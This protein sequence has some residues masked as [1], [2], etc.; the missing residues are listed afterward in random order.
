MI[1]QSSS[2]VQGRV[3]FTDLTGRV[4][5]RLTVIEFSHLAYGQRF[6]RCQCEC[7]SETVH[8][9][10]RLNIG[11]VRSCGCLGRDNRDAC[12]VKHGKSKSMEYRTWAAMIARCENKNSKCYSDY[13]GRG[14]VVC[15]AWRKSFEAFLADMGPRPSPKHQIDRI[16]NNRGYEPRNC[17]WTTHT[18]NQRRTRKSMMVNHEG[19]TQCLSAWVEEFGLNYLLTWRRLRRGISLGSILKM[20]PK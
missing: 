2:T 8:R 7:G 4:F 18:E 17:R 6:W 9:T 1:G 15:E 11:H 20:N 12:I 5:G 13:G 14:I 3:R 10:G 16:D 19:R